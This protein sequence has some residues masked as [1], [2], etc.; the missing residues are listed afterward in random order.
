MGGREDKVDFNRDEKTSIK[1][2]RNVTHYKDE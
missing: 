1:N 2:R